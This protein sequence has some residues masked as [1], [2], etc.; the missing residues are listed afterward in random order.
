MF[1]YVT[2]N[3]PEL[4]IREF[5]EY[6]SWYCG[7][8]RELS[9]RY[10]RPGK[11]TLSYDMTFLIMVLHGLYEPQKSEEKHASGQ[12]APHEQQPFYPIWGGYEH[13]SGV[14]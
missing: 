9:Q 12:Q 7:L 14:S 6:Q 1:G 5:E 3:K 13:P 4:K 10:G 11:I 8:C 2:V